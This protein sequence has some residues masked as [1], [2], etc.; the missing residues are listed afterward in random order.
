M[1]RVKIGGRDSM[2]T[3]NFFTSYEKKNSLKTSRCHSEEL[4]VCGGV[5]S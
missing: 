4:I 3:C 5:D 2:E 1:P